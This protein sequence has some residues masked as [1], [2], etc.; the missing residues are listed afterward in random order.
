[1]KKEIRNNRPMSH[2]ARE[3]IEVQLK[4][5]KEAKRQSCVKMYERHL[6]QLDD[7]RNTPQMFTERLTG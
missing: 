4:A 6:R 2:I 1:M 7:G 3:W 5:S